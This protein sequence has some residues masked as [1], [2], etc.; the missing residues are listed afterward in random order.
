MIHLLDSGHGGIVGG[1]YTT[2]PDKMF[3]HQGHFTFY[4]GE[5]NRM[6]KK[7]VS[8]LLTQQ[9]IKWV[10]VCPTN[11]DLGLDNRVDFANSL[12]KDYGNCLYWSFH[13]NATDTH[14]ATG[15][16]VWTSVG[17]TESDKYAE[18]LAKAIKKD[19]PEEKFREDM[20]DGDLDKESEFYVLKWTRCPA[21][22]LESLFFDN[23]TDA[24]KLINAGWRHR[25]CACIL[26]VIMQIELMK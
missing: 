1:K 2:A 23:Y 19:F 26:G 21:V 3:I 17:Q 15:F 20:S 9:G 6:I 16:E 11:L 10:D 24:Q 22:L 5:F 12:Q 7:E 13:S 8:E 4:E 25:L 14:N 18:M